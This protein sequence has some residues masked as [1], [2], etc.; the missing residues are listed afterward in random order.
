[1]S[2][3]IIG[4]VGASGAGKTTLLRLLAGLDYADQALLSLDNC[5]IEDSKNKIYLANYKRDI[6]Y[7]FQ[8]LIHVP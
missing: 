1:M 2:Q 3:I 6:V 5:I 4:L 8:V 7:Q